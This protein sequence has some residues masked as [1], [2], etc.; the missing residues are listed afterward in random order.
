MSKIHYAFYIRVDTD[1]STY[2]NRSDYHVR[3]QRAQIQ[4]FTV[5]APAS[6]KA[7]K[8]LTNV[9]SFIFL[10]SGR[11]DLSSLPCSSSSLFQ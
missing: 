11:V 1:T 5:V 9:Q 8:K 10:V 3:L 2:T 7:P 6:F 4:A